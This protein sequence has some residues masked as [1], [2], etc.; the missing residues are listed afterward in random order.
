MTLYLSGADHWHPELAHQPGSASLART[1]LGAPRRS[2]AQAGHIPVGVHRASVLHCRRS[3]FVSRW[4]LRLLSDRVLPAAAARLIAG[5]FPIMPLAALTVRARTVW[6]VL[7]GVPVTFAPVVRVAVSPHSRLC[8]PGWAGLVVIAGAAIATAP[9]VNT[10]QT[11]QRVLGT[12]PAAS[13]ADAT[14]LTRELVI[15]DMLGPASLA[16]LDSAEFRPAPGQAAATGLDTSSPAL[17]QFL[18]ETATSDLAESGIA[19]ITSPAFVIREEDRIIAAAGY[20]D[21]TGQVAHLSVLTAA[22][23]RARG[24]GGAV[25]SAAVMHA[26]DQDKLPQWRARPEASRRIARRLGFRD[27]GAQVSIRLA[28]TSSSKESVRA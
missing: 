25:A 3:P 5:I 27:L 4:S 14:V 8:P 17:R 20:R 15:A 6:E 21:W 22:N 10:R 13:V 23:A 11:M 1:P 7:A 12:V 2:S 24:L 16:Y 9:D 26:L 18:A 19:E 28:D